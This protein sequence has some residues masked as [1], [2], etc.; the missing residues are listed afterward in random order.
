MI[1]Y[2]FLGVDSTTADRAPCTHEY[3]E[4]QNSLF[5]WIESN[6]G[7]INPKVELSTGPDENWHIRGVFATAPM[8]EGEKLF[9]LPPAVQICD[10]DMC[11]LVAKVRDE[12]VKG[13]ESFYWPYILAMDHRVDL[14]SIWNEHERSLLEGLQPTD[15]QRHLIWYEHTCK[16]DIN[17]AHHLRAMLLTVARS[18]GDGN[19]YCMSPFYDSANHANGNHLNTVTRIEGDN[20]EKYLTQPIPAGGQVFVSI[21]RT[22]VGRL[23]RDY[24]FISQYPR[25]WAFEGTDGQ[26]YVFECFDENGYMTVDTNPFD[27][28]HQQSPAALA[29]QLKH[30][31]DALEATLIPEFEEDDERVDPWR[32]RIALEYRAEYIHAM[33]TA[34]QA[35]NSLIESRG[36]I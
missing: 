8:E 25:L 16:G 19:D 13:E 7:Y 35:T 2:L 27:F 6:G 22:D 34:L 28:P 17:D 1:F 3:C 18:S 4:V 14:P 9:S 12:L 26:D 24:G 5:N 23:F 21:G 20:F 29:K 32:H 33:K 36:E 15:W 31:V 11:G 10:T 30:Q